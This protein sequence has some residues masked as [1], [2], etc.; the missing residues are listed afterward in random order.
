[1][2]DINNY[3]LEKLHI[4]KNLQ[5]NH[6][7][8]F[9]DYLDEHGWRIDKLNHRRDAYRIAGKDNKGYPCIY[10]DINDEHTCWYCSGPANN[11]R[12]DVIKLW[13]D[14]RNLPYRYPADNYDKLKNGMFAFSLNNAKEIVKILDDNK[15]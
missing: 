9:I 8:E 10:I 13:Y 4:S 1:M 6:E 7:Q 14:M 15:K 5:S 2:I 12:N 11:Q 3:I